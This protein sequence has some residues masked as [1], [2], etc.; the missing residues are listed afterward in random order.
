[1]T[2]LPYVNMGCIVLSTLILA[3]SNNQGVRFINAGAV[4]INVMALAM[5]QVGV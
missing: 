5:R 3:L 1:M 4:L 2:Y